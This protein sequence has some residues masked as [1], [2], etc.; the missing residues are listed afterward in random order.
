MAGKTI[1]AHIL[2]LLSDGHPRTAADIAQ[3]LHSRIDRTFDSI[4]TETSY[5]RDDRRIRRHR[6]RGRYVY[7]MVG[8]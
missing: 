3:E 5:L 1:R 6:R 8:A 4:M 2:E 7:Q